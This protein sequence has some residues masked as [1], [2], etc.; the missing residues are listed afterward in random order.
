[1]SHGAPSKVP[2]MGIYWGMFSYKGDEFIRGAESN[3]AVGINIRGQNKKG[4][5]SQKTNS[6]LLMGGDGANRA[7]KKKKLK[8][9]EV[10]LTYSRRSLSL[11]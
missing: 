1:M 6:Y 2:L 10:D 3:R 7:R 9:D 11:K 4:V 5:A 8:K